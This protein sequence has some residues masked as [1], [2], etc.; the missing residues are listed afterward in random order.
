[1]DEGLLIMG[2][3]QTYLL[4]NYRIPNVALFSTSPA[5]DEADHLLLLPHHLLLPPLLLHLRPVP[6]AVL[7]AGKV[8]RGLREAS[9]LPRDELLSRAASQF[10]S[11]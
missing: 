4:T 7:L 10:P 2:N 8:N 11:H 6:Q 3:A 9:L 5:G 1:M